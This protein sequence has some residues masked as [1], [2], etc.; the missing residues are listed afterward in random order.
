MTYKYIKRLWSNVSPHAEDDDSSSGEGAK[1][2][3]ESEI[4]PSES[5][6]T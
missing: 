2:D 1:E 4:L 6:N 5:Q 3:S